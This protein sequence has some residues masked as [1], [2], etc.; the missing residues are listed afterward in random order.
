MEY[1]KEDLIGRKFSNKS[2]GLYKFVTGA[3]SKNHVFVENI[4]S[5][6]RGYHKLEIV[7]G[8]LNTGTWALLDDEKVVEDKFTCLEQTLLSE[9]MKHWAKDINFHK[10]VVKWAN[11][12][13]HHNCPVSILYEFEKLTRHTSLSNDILN[14]LSNPRASMVAKLLEHY[15]I[16]FIDRDI[17]FDVRK[18]KTQPLLDATLNYQKAFKEAKKENKMQKFKRGDSIRRVGHTVLPFKDNPGDVEVRPGDILTVRADTNG[19]EVFTKEF[20][21]YSFTAE[22]F[23]LVEPKSVTDPH[24]DVVM[25][26]HDHPWLK[27]HLG[28]LPKIG[29]VFTTTGT[30]EGE[31]SIEGKTFPALSLKGSSYIYPAECF[32]LAEDYVP[33]PLNTKIPFESYNPVTEETKFNQ[34]TEEEIMKES[35]KTINNIAVN[36]GNDYY[37]EVTTIG[38]RGNS[39]EHMTEAEVYSVLE[40][41]NAEQDSLKSMNKTLKSS[42]VKGQIAKL[43]AAR[44]KIVAYLDSLPDSTS[45]D[46]DES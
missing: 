35:V 15:T 43:G 22:S 2:N 11:K 29:K 7:A 27:Q 3:S 14:T 34:P 23:E 37:T 44:N 41:L 6:K 17:T 36:I 12:H 38:I 42:R 28:I 20:P 21:G 19:K 9:W 16:T 46:Y 25:V 32:V 10:A 8:H 4:N 45:E 31:R 5:G 40:E 24:T 13:K 1:K 39:V 33:E 26:T 18:T 30:A